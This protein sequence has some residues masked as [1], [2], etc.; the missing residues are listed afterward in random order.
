MTQIPSQ[1]AAGYPGEGGSNIGG[2]ESDSSHSSYNTN[3]QIVC[4]GAE[5]TNSGSV[6]GFGQATTS[7]ITSLLN[8]PTFSDEDI[9]G[10]QLHY[11]SQQNLSYWNTMQQQQSSMQN[12]YSSQFAGNNSPTMFGGPSEGTANEHLVKRG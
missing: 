1:N 12:P 2:Y 8:F 4:G 10:N 9:P 6:I 11:G 5:F 7:D 3:K